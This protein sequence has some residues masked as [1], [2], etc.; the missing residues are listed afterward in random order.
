M[1][2]IIVG[3]GKVGET[4]ANNFI[5]EGHDVVAI[6]KDA[7]ALNYVANKYDVKGIIGGGLERD[8]LIDSGIEQADLFVAC[9]SRDEM[10]IL[11]CVLAKRL[12][13]KHT[14][15]R[16]RDPE[17]FKEM[18]NMREVLG[19][20]LVFNPELRTALEIAE[21]LKFPSAKN[22]ESFA[23][24]KATLVE[25]DI[26]EGNPLIGKTLMDISS[27]GCKVL[28]ALISRGNKIFIPRGDFI[29]EENDSVHVM[30][31]EAE[32]AQFCKKLKIFKPRARSVFIIGGGKIAYYL[33]K[34]LISTGVDVK[35]MESDK[36]RCQELSEEL[37]S[38]TI[39]HGDGT[40]QETLDEENLK[41][42]DACVT[43][44][45]IDEENIIIS[46][47]AMQKRVGKVITKIDR[48]TVVNMVKMLGLDT[49]VSPKNAIANHIIRFVRAHQA[50]TN[51]GGINTLYKLHD[52]AEALEF[53]I[54]KSFK[55]LG[56]PL[57]KL[58]VKSAFLVGGVVRN[59][60]FTIANGNTEF[61]VGDKAIIFTANK[62][63][64]EFSEIFRQL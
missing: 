4:L 19:L 51:A 28:F 59:G 40:D 44:T 18:E 57:K 60:V 21:V 5:K 37:L 31:T 25:F 7:V 11:A 54:D 41:G 64:K 61:E 27:Y 23:N 45:G 2:I 15:A 3:V 47:Y 22:V 53:T 35:I 10:N 16:V 55:Q 14:V 39:L 17:Y 1:N 9:T 63:I 26:S 56:V 42:S 33:A 24:G 58:K 6:D 62:Q 48:E 36:E 52:K 38:V 12:G 34:A 29:I 50:D 30:G 13:A 49:V 8:V 46:L 20:D 43:L 32:L